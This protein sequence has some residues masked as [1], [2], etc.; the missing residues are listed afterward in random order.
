M[1]VKY[2]GFATATPPFYAPGPSLASRHNGTVSPAARRYQEVRDRIARAA[3]G[4]HRDPTDVCLVAVSKTYPVEA[5]RELYDLGHR[6]FG[7]SR[8]QEA[9]PKIESLPSDITWHFIG[10]L[11]SNKARQ[12]AEQMTVIHTIDNERQLAAIERQSALTQIFIEVNLARE[13]QKAG[14]F[15]EDLDNF[16]PC[17]ANYRKVQLLGLMTIGPAEAELEEQGR[18]F[19]QLA[20]MAQGVGLEQ[21]SMGMSGDF[22]TAIAHG[23][24]HVRIGSSLFGSRN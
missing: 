4:A 13:P 1:G 18:L 6:H 10:H 15:P 3:E 7:E 19:R 24:T 22:E 21:L 20:Q 5:I 12:V 2:V 17:V 16:L 9:R 14:I 23:A 8:W 11:Q